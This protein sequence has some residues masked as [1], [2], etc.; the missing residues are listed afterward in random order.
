MAHS[1]A[2]Q[3]PSGYS[4]HIKNI[5]L[6]GAT[7][8][9]GSYL[10]AALNEK[11]TFNITA[12][13]RADSKATFPE[14]MNVTRVDYDDPSTVIAALKDIDAL[15]ITLA[16]FAPKDTSA[17][18]FRAAAEAGVKWVLPNEL[19]MY[20]TEEA[21]EE[22]IGD[23]KSKD[24]KL[25]EE[26][27]LSWVGVTSGFWYEYSLS[28][29]EGLYGFDI[30]KREVTFFDD[31]TQKLNTS[32]WLQCGRGVAN[33]LSLPILP[34]DKEDKTVTLSAYRNR[35]IYISSFAVSQRDM[36]DSLKRVTGTSDSDWK[37]SSVPAK[38]RFTE[39]K[40]RM[41]KGDFKAFGSVLYT[42][43]F[44]PEAGLFEKSH[45]L[46]NE[47]LG[48]PKE[49]MDEATKRAVKLLESGK[50]WKGGD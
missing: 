41:M 20:N 1:Y 29:G 46:E 42:R 5:A 44:F 34:K 18:L 32:T 31:G 22:T 24:R 49:D 28:G 45:G 25:I 47:K 17:K 40:E 6:V 4:N 21:Q 15:I 10:Y 36:F 27:G 11:N 50:N 43:Y 26:L 19:G 39:A 33:L 8:Q 2:T 16:V 7:G 38:D 30:A 12:I 3:Q 35:M 23:Y 9:V 48:L 37:I 14:S 13:S